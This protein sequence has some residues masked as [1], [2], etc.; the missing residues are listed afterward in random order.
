MTNPSK[1]T[2][3]DPTANTDG[4]PIA[5][6]EITGYQVGVRS[7]GGAAG[8]YPTLVSAAATDSS[9]VVPALAAGSYAAAVQTLSA[10]NGNSAWSGEVT[11]SIVASPNP[12]SGFTVA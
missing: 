9:A 6:G 7:S 8:T 1:F 3:A 10:S 5:S 4:S 2:W 11:F 12:P